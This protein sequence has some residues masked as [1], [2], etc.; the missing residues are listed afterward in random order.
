[1][2]IPHKTL[3][4][5]IPCED[6][7]LQKTAGDIAGHYLLSDWLRSAPLMFYQKMA[8]EYAKYLLGPGPYPAHPSLE[9]SDPAMHLASIVLSADSSIYGDEHTRLPAAWWPTYNP[10]HYGNIMHMHDAV[11]TASAGQLANGLRRLRNLPTDSLLQTSKAA[12]IEEF[13]GRI[14]RNE[15]TPRQQSTS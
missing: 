8:N 14:R 11:G 12:R 10:T 15:N 2:A 1:M 5:G 7:C 9:V 6:R 13:L 3:H 4:G